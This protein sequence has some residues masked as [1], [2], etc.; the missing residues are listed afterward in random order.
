MMNFGPLEWTIIASYSLGLLL[1]G[2]LIRWLFELDTER[3]AKELIHYAIGTYIDVRNATAQ[4]I[5][6]APESIAAIRREPTPAEAAPVLNR[7][8]RA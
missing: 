2:Y 8:K 1:C 6:I 3:T 7:R 4:P 5:V